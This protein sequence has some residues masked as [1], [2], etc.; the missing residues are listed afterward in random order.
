MHKTLVLL[1]VG[2]VVCALVLAG[3]GGGGGGS[4]PDM[5]SPL[6]PL[7]ASTGPRTVDS[8]AA[9]SPGRYIVF[10]FVANRPEGPLYGDVYLYDR[11]TGA[12]DTLPAMN[13]GAHEAWP[14][15]SA[16]GRYIA[17]NS[18]RP[19]GRG[20]YHVFLY[21][22][23]A[24][25]LDN[26][27]GLNSTAR[28]EFPSISADG[29]YIVFE[30]T[31]AG[32]RHDTGIYLYDRMTDSVTS[33]PKLLPKG[34]AGVSRP[35]ISG[36]ASYIAFQS[37]YQ[38]RHLTYPVPRG[39]ADVCLYNR[40]KRS[41]VALPGLKGPDFGPS[42][43]SSDCYPAISGDGRYIAFESNRAGGAG[44]RDV[45]LYDCNRK[46]LVPLPGLNTTGYDGRPGISSD[47][48]YIV[49]RGPWG[50]SD[51]RLYDCSTGTLANVPVNPN[52]GGGSVE[53]PRLN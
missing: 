49:L 38:E 33:P 12:L 34:S 2:V 6:S 31:R 47:G 11:E 8:Q 43:P 1:S 26:L 35:S 42:W 14:S 53:E 17:F 20:E 50:Y 15:I 16:D 4:V 39:W 10:V 22:R 3:C 25:S 46:A 41:L 37:G 9:V 27:P 44:D 32:G 18:D 24:N 23:S 51:V 45:Y 48:R 7:T 29:R 52:P 28:D 30:S 19:N 13:S 40:A 36:D 21:D 5:S